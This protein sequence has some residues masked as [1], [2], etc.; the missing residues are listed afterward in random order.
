ML[1]ALLLTGMVAAPPASGALL[2]PGDPP[3]TGSPHGVGLPGHPAVGASPASARILCAAAQF[4]NVKLR[5][6]ADPPSAL[7]GPGGGK[8]VGA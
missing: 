2:L 8:G 3:E 6:L 4:G 7:G 1:A 5:G